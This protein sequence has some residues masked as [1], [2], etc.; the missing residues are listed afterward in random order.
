MDK[1]SYKS[2]IDDRLSTIA[3]FVRQNSRVADIGC[4]HGYL[5]CSLALDGKI[6]SGIASDI[7]VKPLEAA[8]KE[9]KANGLNDIIA[10]R[11]GSGL[12]NVS[13]DEVDDIVIAGMGGETIAKIID[14]C[15]WKTD[16]NKRYILQPM[17]KAPDLRRWLFNNGFSIEQEKICIADGKYYA[18]MATRFSKE[19]KNIGLYD[20]DSYVGRLETKLAITKTYIKKSVQSL[21]KKKNGLEKQGVEDTEEITKLIDCLKRSIEED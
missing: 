3:D 16:E 11:L 10:C 20:Y 2:K 8:I 6:V 14:E 17:S 4:D 12:D 21:L 19:Y 13:A 18:V 1:K 15:R 7:N 9:I 5:I